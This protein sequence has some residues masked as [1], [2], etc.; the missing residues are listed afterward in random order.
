MSRRRPDPPVLQRSLQQHEPLSE[1]PATLSP[2]APTQPSGNLEP[3]YSL[4]PLEQHN[5]ISSVDG[6]VGRNPSIQST[7]VQLPESTAEASEE[8]FSWT[9][10]AAEGLLKLKAAWI[11]LAA[12]VSKLRGGGIKYMQKPYTEYRVAQRDT[13]NRTEI[14]L[15]EPPCY[16]TMC[17]MWRKMTAMQ[18]EAFFSSDARLAT[19][20]RHHCSYDNGNDAEVSENADNDSCDSD[21]QEKGEESE[22]HDR[23]EASSSDRR[24]G[25]RAARPQKCHKM[26]TLAEGMLAVDD[27]MKKLQKPS[28]LQ[29]QLPQRL[30]QTQTKLSSFNKLYLR[31][32][33]VFAFQF[34]E[35]WSLAEWSSIS[36]ASY[37]VLST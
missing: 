28:Q 17:D 6:S 29:G 14:P 21:G 5:H 27:G 36:L 26:L 22:Q 15:R 34:Y 30:L 11:M 18:S 7:Q 12:K 37:S 9:V 20:R 13:G 25:W 2:I 23:R 10:R 33:H 35:A 19:D 24:Q 32:H 1:T 16:D 4:S 3:S 8:P 31:F